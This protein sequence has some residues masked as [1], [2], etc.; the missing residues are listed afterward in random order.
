M[1]D[2]GGVKLIGA[3]LRLYRA[4][5]RLRELQREYYRSEPGDNTA[6]LAYLRTLAEA[7]TNYHVLRR[8]IG[9]TR[10]KSRRV[11]LG[12]GDHR[13]DGWINVDLLP[14]N[15]TDVQA[16]LVRSLPFRDA[17]IDYLHTEDFLEHITLEEGR[18]FLAECRRVLRP[19]GVLRVLT[20]DLHAIIDRV[21][22]GRFDEHL[23]WCSVHLGAESACEAMN[24]HM[25]MN[26]AHRFLYDG[27]QLRAELV[28]AGFE[29]H[30]T[31][32]NSSRHPELRFIDLRDFG[33]N[34]FVEGTKKG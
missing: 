21:Y 8:I 3:A 5:A 24:M 14:S 9:R 30:E 17:S 23:D 19:G 2:N 4:T 29:P 11:H 28:R 31:A 34:L 33:L 10:A 7:R 22:H 1:R 32:W 13:I 25:R 26:G 18:A 12:C 20:P 16:D 6:V 15:A 27:E